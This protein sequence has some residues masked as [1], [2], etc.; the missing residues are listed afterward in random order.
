MS[1]DRYH[2]IYTS[3]VDVENLWESRDYNHQCTLRIAAIGIQM[4]LAVNEPMSKT[5]T[6][7]NTFSETYMTL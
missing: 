2:N 4:Y 3:A 1:Q 6:Y 7:K 5:Q